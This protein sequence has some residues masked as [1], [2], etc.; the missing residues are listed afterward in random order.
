MT[1]RI[2]R[3][4]GRRDADRTGDKQ[5][6]AEGEQ[7]AAGRMK[8]RRESPTE[9]KRKK[10]KEPA[11]VEHKAYSVALQIISTLQ[12]F[13]LFSQAKLKLRFLSRWKCAVNYTHDLK[14]V[15]HKDSKKYH[16]FSVKSHFE[17]HHIN[18]F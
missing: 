17:R 7:T 8:S 9:E 14:K 10:R 2:R 3:Q 16:L 18:V 1:A 5:R 15:C 12:P 4:S 11:N 6:A 13:V